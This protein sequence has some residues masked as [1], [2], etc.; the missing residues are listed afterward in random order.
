M[1]NE[2]TPAR[3]E[4]YQAIDNLRAAMI[5]VVMF[6]HA[7]LPYVT[8]P[9]RFK[10]PMTHPAFDVVALFLYSFAMP[11]FFVT[12]GFAAAALLDRRGFQGLVTN[13][14]RAIFLPLLIAYLTLTPLTRA[15]YVF[16]TEVATSGTIG[17]GIDLLLEG[18][19]LRWGKAYH[20]WFLVSLLLYTGLVLA[21]RSLLLR[22]LGQRVS[23]M[24]DAARLLFEKPW[25]T[26]L[27]SLLAIIALIPAYSLND[28][29]ATTLPM[30]LH[31]FSFFLVG[32]LLYRH[33]DLLADL[34]SRTWPW[35]VAAL[36]VTPAAAW[37]ARE[38]WYAPDQ[39][40]LLVGTIAGASNGILVACVSLG[41]LG[42]FQQRFDQR[43]SPV[44]Q[45]LSEASYWIFLIHLPLLI[46]VGGALSATPLP[47]LVKYLLTVTI[48]VPLVLATYHFLVRT[49]A[50][51]RLL[52][53]RRNTRSARTEV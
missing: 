49:S 12:A 18:R 25:R 48:V 37:S 10:D 21:S 38:R 45:Y 2:A 14:V 19:W 17:A 1:A 41:L 39:T 23:R 40:D 47:A 22:V 28:G 50:L 8:V 26:P 30:Q 51:G 11:L 5:C 3:H 13:R 31:L 27:L 46:L 16:A 29:D 32:W 6:G 43:P 4:R 24:A 15:A 9:R 7:L 36:A 53:G 33:R 52:K 20:L 44:G 34:R 42:Y 35:F